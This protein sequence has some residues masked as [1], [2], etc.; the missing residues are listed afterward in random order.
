MRSVIFLA[1]IILLLGACQNASKENAQ[2]KGVEDSKLEATDDAKIMGTYG[3]EIDAS[4]AV[5][6]DQLAKKLEEVDSAEVKVV[7]TI[8]KTCAVKGCWM[9]VKLDDKDEMRVTFKDYGF[10]VPKEGMEGKK[11][12]F[13]GIVKKNVTSVESLKHFAKDAGKSQEEIDA[14][15]DPKEEIVFEASGV[16]I[17]DAD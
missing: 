13:E 10:F 9:S 3:A 1:G 8:V 15:T 14:I 5:T 12:T 6:T 2:T 16:I 4:G 11:V 7:S 17:E